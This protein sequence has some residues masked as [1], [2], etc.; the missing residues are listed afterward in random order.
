MSRHSTHRLVYQPVPPT[1]HPATEI[2]AQYYKHPLSLR[3]RARVRANDKITSLRI[4]PSPLPSPEG[5]GRNTLDS[6]SRLTFLYRCSSVPHRW[7][8]L[9]VPPRAQH[10]LTPLAVLHTRA[11]YSWRSRRNPSFFEQ[12][13][14]FRAIGRCTTVVTV[15]QHATYVHFETGTDYAFVGVGSFSTP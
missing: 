15:V 9:F 13:F 10:G 4:S 6:P 8:N 11:E 7:L 1:T 3:E 5:R 12:N 2:D 14:L